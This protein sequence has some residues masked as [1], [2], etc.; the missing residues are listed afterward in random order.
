[1]KN[2]ILAVAC[3]CLITLLSWGQKHKTQILGTA[4]IDNTSYLDQ[5]EVTLQEWIFFI[6]NNNFN[7]DF[8]PDPKGISKTA[9][10]LFDDIRKGKD[11]AYIKLNRN[12][13]PI[14]QHYGTLGFTLTKEFNR[15]VEADSNYFSIFVPITGISF[16]QANAFCSWRESNAN[17]NTAVQVNISLPSIGTYEKVI[18]NIDS[19]NIK[20]CYLLNSLSCP[21]VISTKTKAYQSQGKSLLQADAYWPSD[22]NFY[23]LQGNASEMTNTEGI[24]MGGSFRHYARES[25]KDRKQYY[26]K[27]EDWLGFRCLV[28][29]K[30]R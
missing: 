7:P 10:A 18:E 23:C 4:P 27:P 6:I 2:K 21:C 24:A 12:T 28:T 3:F 29:I 17:S 9:I 19:M 5:T 8:F 16:R 25:L 22:K 20:K 13:K 30:N 26:S 11:F 15:L 1:M 14:G